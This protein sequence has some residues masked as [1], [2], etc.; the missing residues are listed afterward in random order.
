MFLEV[1]VGVGWS[2]LWVNTQHT[3]LV[4]SGVLGK[5]SADSWILIGI[6]AIVYNRVHLDLTVEKF[7]WGCM[8]NKIRHR[9]ANVKAARTAWPKNLGSGS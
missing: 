9:L 5:Q 4:H 6:G 8:G 2:I 3:T 1:M 7:T